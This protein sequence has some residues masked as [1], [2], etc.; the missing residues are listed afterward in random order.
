MASLEDIMKEN[1][2]LKAK[3]AEMEEALKKYTNGERH[4]RY[5]DTHKEEVKS[6]AKA[7]MDKVKAENPEKI[8]EWRRNAYLKAKA[9]KAEEASTSK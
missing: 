9:K 7:Y 5:Y 4:Q 8:K 2:D 1:A 3:L 6:R